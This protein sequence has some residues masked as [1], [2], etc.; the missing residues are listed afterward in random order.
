VVPE[1]AT[2]LS[3]ASRLRT[4]GAIVALVVQGDLTAA[5]PAVSGVVT[6]QQ[7]GDALFQAVELYGGP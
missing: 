5:A 3:V 6:R 4:S 2:V 1:D 7:L